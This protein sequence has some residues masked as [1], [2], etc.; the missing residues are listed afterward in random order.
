M[1]IILKL[2]YNT[3]LGAAALII[4]NLIGK[5]MNFHIALN[6]VTAIVVGILGIPGFILLIILRLLFNVA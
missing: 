3:L 4:V 2:F 6:L 5:L 1:K